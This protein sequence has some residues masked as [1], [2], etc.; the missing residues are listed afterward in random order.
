M[1]KRH[2]R[3]TLGKFVTGITVVTTEHDGD[4]SGM[5]ANAFMSVSLVPPLILVSVDQQASMHE[6]IMKAGRFAVSILSKEQKEVS[7]H[8]A[9]QKRL[10]SVD[11]LFGRLAGQPILKDALANLVCRLHEAHPAGDHTL[12][13]GEVL[14][15]TSRNG[16]PLTYYQGKYGYLE[17]N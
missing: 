12:F 14:E 5:T 16:E 8:F 4:I 13:I 3:Q 17:D 7:M 10:D 2:F 1:E 6:K 15:L 11:G 9:K